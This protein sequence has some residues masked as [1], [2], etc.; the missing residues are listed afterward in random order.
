MPLT[1]IWGG[2]RLR[3]SVTWPSSWRDGSSLRSPFKRHLKHNVSYL[4]HLR[5]FSR[6]ETVD[7]IDL[8]YGNRR[9]L[10][11]QE[12][13]GWSFLC[14]FFLGRVLDWD[15][16][17]EWRVGKHEWENPSLTIVCERK[18]LFFFF[19]CCQLPFLSS[20][21]AWFRP[22]SCENWRVLFVDISFNVAAAKTMSP[23]ENETT[24]HLVELKSWQIKQSIF[25]FFFFHFQHL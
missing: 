14:C 10:K 17:S 12:H 6:C 23:S 4:R 15:T 2:G 25:F 5:L 7:L 13:S 11:A 19:F 3:P 20:S 22:T 18:E 8:G 1:L 16:S 21:S 24:K 9:G